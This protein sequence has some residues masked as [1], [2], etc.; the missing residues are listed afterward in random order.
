M[1]VLI[2]GAGVAGSALA[3][4]LAR[5]DIK[6]TILERSKSQ[7][8]QGQNVDISGSAVMVL[9]KMGL[10]EEVRKNNT[11]E[12]GTIFLDRAG[13]EI[14]KFPAGPEEMSPTR[15]LEILR[16]DLA[17]LFYDAVKDH[18]NVEIL[19]ETSIQ[20]LIS[21]DDKSVKV[22]LSNDQT[23]EY[24]IAFAADGQWSTLR[25][26]AFSSESIKI[27]DRNAYCGY[28]TI[29]KQAEDTEWWY[30]YWGLKSRVS[31]LRPDPHGTMRV[32]LTKM[33][34][35][36]DE[37]ETWERVVRGDKK[38][39]IELVKHHFEGTGW[40]TQR[41]L[42]AIDSSPDFYL[43]ALQQ[44]KMKKWSTGRVV[45]LG[46]AAHAATPITGMG[47]TLAILG[48]YVLAGE[49]AELQPGEQ[50][51]KAFDAYEAKFHKYTEKVQD[52]PSFVPGIAHP[53]SKWHLW[54]LEAGVSA[55]SAILPLVSKVSKVFGGGSGG[56]E[57]DKGF[58]LP[59]YDT[60]DKKIARTA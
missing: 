26:L 39:Q 7:L 45:C 3:W 19:F 6:V 52:V 35:D 14:G 44:I 49:L 10:H 8:A 40:Q 50:P 41:F 15:E 54:A 27:V 28:W 43:Q 17:V 57:S 37:K 53:A 16:G 38:T 12:K 58:P 60:L 36:K 32:C 22:K 30:I 5:L 33:P 29:P 23:N 20:E 34:L 48:A 4:F 25:K 56:E 24:D 1:H 11:T 46:D 42:D 9:K 55:V 21:N 2:S 59:K 51:Q 18:P 47:T 13:K 31:S